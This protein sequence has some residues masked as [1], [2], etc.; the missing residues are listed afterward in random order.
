MHVEKFDSN[1]SRIHFI[2]VLKD[3]MWNMKCMSA[4]PAKISSAKMI[5]S[6]SMHFTIVPETYRYK[7]KK[8]SFSNGSTHLGYRRLYKS[9]T[10][11]AKFSTT[12]STLPLLLGLL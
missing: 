10:F 11:K 3:N 9:T 4:E 6:K 2:E 7:N 8:Y 12:S 5:C 1:L